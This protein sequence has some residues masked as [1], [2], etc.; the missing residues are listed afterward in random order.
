LASDIL[1]VFK[2]NMLPEAQRLLLFVY[3]RTP[4]AICRG[5]AVDLLLGIGQAPEWLI[6]ECKH[7][8]YE[9]TREAVAEK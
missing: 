8:V 2:V 4:C 5:I 6:D 3:E 7:D 1:D 9:P